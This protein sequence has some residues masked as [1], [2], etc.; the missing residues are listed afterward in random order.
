MKKRGTRT[1]AAIFPFERELSVGKL[2]T[3]VIASGEDKSALAG[4][5]PEVGAVYVA[6]NGGPAGIR[7]R[8]VWLPEG[9]MDSWST[10]LEESFHH[11]GWR[12]V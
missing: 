6:V 12:V 8:K 10:M 9:T 1:P 5:E 7:L 3:Y 4:V 11:L 2:L